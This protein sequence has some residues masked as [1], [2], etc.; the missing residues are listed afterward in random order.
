[1]SAYT[2]GGRYSDRKTEEGYNDPTAY[3]AMGGY[4]VGEWVKGD[5]VEWERTNG[6]Y[7]QAV[8]L[9]CHNKFCSAMELFEEEA[10][11]NNHK[12]LSRSVMNGNAGKIISL[13]YNRITNLIKA[14]DDEPFAKL[15]EHVGLCMGT[16]GTVEKIVEKEVPV[17]KVKTVV[18]EIPTADSTEI[19]VKL[20]RV[21]AERD[22]FKTLYM[23]LLK[24]GL[25]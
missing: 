19:A 13:Y 21:E 15:L 20:A 17:E 7:G 4:N 18:K 9:S 24:G 5:I 11:E 14:M 25:A 6:T 12:V 22:T 1:M 16:V 10:D 23:D 3:K 2:G 8:V